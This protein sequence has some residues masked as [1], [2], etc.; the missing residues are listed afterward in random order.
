MNP[1]KIITLLA[2]LLI[3][4]GGFLLAFKNAPEKGVKATSVQGHKEDN[5]PPSELLDGKGNKVN[6][7]DFH[8]KI[9]F[10]NNW[11]SW[12]P[13]CIAEMPTIKALKASLP[14]EEVA[15]IMVSYDRNPQKGIDWMERKGIDLPV[16]F[17]GENFPQQFITRSIPTTFILDRE[18]KLLHR[19]MGMA[20]Y[21]SE[22]FVNQM[23]K[24]IA[25]DQELETRNK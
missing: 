19:Q 23:K 6:F 3:L 20:D 15:F 8:G 9:V 4:G 1:N 25:N 17:P 14:P 18:G 12:C 2:L 16:Y 11:A 5:K 21:S 10:I 13:P 24:W 22:K 7:Q